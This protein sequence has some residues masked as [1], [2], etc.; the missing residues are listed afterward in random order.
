[1]MGVV[2][3]NDTSYK[4]QFSELSQMKSAIAQVRDAG[5]RLSTVGLNSSNDEIAAELKN[6]VGKYNSWIERFNPDMQNGGVLADT[7]AA[8]VSRYELDQ[9]IKNIFNGAKD[10]VHGLA[11]LGL[12]IDP[13]SKLA[14]LDTA[15]LDSLLGS[16]RLGAV[17]ALQEFSGNFTKSATLL[18]S[19]GNFIPNRLNNLHKVIDYYAENK[20]SLQNEF[21]TGDVPQSTGQV[22]RALAAYNLRYGA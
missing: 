12:T 5:Q 7:Q 21:G 18:N 13:A 16:N 1:M 6:F 2:N 19:D 8:Q 3:S 20:T 17:D 11:D 15:R 22:A 14:S 4:A 9:S 10:G